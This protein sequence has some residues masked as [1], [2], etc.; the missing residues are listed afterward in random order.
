M[1][2]AMLAGKSLADVQLVDEN[3]NPYAIT[4]EAIKFGDD[5]TVAMMK[6]IIIELEEQKKR[7]LLNI[8][9]LKEELSEQKKE[10]ADVYYYLNKKLDDNFETIANVE[11]Q[12]LNEQGDREIAD[13][14]YERKIEELVSKAS[15]DESRSSSR[16]GGNCRA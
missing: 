8:V 15:V 10:Q 7:L 16:I 4:P 13:R 11:E 14:M 1:A 2:E 9:Q 3:G 12:L 5:L 6:D